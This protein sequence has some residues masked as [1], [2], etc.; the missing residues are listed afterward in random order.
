[1]TLPTDR[2]ARLSL[3]VV[4]AWARARVAGN[5]DPDVVTCRRLV[6]Y[7]ERGSRGR[8]DERNR[9]SSRCNPD[10][11]PSPVAAAPDCGHRVRRASVA[12]NPQ[13]L[14]QLRDVVIH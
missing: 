11:T 14:K 1:V 6:G 4:P 3:V 7:R 2:L 5:A 12:V 8:T 9:A 10:C 13:C